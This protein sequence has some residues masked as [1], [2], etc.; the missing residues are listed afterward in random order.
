VNSYPPR[1]FV[2]TIREQ[3][4]PVG[5]DSCIATV[6]PGVYARVGD[7]APALDVPVLGKVLR[8][9]SEE[10]AANIGER[11]HHAEWVITDD[12]AVVEEIGMHGRPDCGKCRG[13]VDQALARLADRR[14]ELLVG[15]LYWAEPEGSRT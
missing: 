10:M 4:P 13:S 12:P 5:S 11:L 3:R 2:R 9:L 6:P 15:V 7:G 14:Q 8:K 1:Y